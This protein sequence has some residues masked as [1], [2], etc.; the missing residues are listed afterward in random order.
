MNH[1]LNKVPGTDEWE[2]V[3]K[4]K[5]RLQRINWYNIFVATFTECPEAA[6]QFDD[7]PYAK[8]ACFATF[9][10]QLD[11]VWQVDKRS[12]GRNGT[13]SLAANRFA[14]GVPW[15]YDSFDMLLYGKKTQIEPLAEV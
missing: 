2:G 7:L 10:S 6:E 11:S 3:V 8:K 13:I 4:W 12:A 14:V 15:F 9:P 1:Y 5:E